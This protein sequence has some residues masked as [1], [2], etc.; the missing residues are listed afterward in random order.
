MPSL[1]KVIVA[2]LVA[3]FIPVLVNA[4]GVGVY[5]PYSMGIEADRTSTDDWTGVESEYSYELERKSGLG[6]AFAT[7]LGQERVF[8]YKFALEF[9]NPKS[10]TWTNSSDKIE[11][12]HTFEFGIAR[13]QDVKFWIGPRINMGYETFDNSSYERDGIEFGVGPAVGININL[14]QQ[15]T[16]A[17]DIDYKY[18]WQGGSWSTASGDGTYES[19]ITGA[20]ARLG[21]FYR[22]NE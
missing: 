8:G 14:G 3:L 20:T 4:G 2:A 1:K 9:T 11:M 18:A 15:F 13:T 22:F 6:I 10:K 12:L 21:V 16:I 7:N 19:D 17:F 5:V